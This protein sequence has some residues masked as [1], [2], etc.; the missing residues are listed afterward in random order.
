MPTTTGQK[1]NA[2]AVLNLR[3]AAMTIAGT[4]TLFSARAT[5]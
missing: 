3:V 1:L 4:K 5:G 2:T